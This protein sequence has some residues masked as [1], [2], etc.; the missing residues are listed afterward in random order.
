MRKP[1]DLTDK[2]K[3]EILDM[4]PTRSLKD[5]SSELSIPY[6]VVMQVNLS[7][8]TTQVEDHRVHS[9]EMKSLVLDYVTSAR[10]RFERAPT[11][12]ENGIFYK[13]VASDE[14]EWI[15]ND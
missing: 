5:I 3:K 2:I 11:I 10:E 7:L 9:N 8:V 4:I 13:R 12:E 1:F 6:H 15:K 14:N